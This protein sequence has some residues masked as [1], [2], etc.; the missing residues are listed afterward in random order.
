MPSNSLLCSPAQKC[1]TRS[2]ENIS[3]YSVLEQ[4][5]LHH[6]LSL[7]LSFILHPTFYFIS[8][9][10]NVTALHMNVFTYKIKHVSGSW[11]VIAQH[12]L[13]QCYIIIPGARR[14]SG[15]R[16]CSRLCGT[17]YRK[18]SKALTIYSWNPN[19]RRSVLRLLNQ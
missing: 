5:F 12:A 7:F 18:S 17:A 14:K 8:L 10:Q 9:F 1:Y 6:F 19:P 4:H 2:P 15:T 13:R 16:D 11:S 3:R